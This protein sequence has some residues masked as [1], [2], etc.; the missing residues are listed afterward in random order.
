[1]RSFFY[2]FIGL[3]WANCLIAGQKLEVFELQNRDAESLVPVIA[4]TLGPEARVTADPRTNSLLVSYPEEMQENLRAIIAQLDQIE[5]NIEVETVTFDVEIAYLEKLGLTAR[6][7]L[8]PEDYATVLPLLI[9]DRRA[10][11]VGRQSVTTRGNQPARLSLYSAPA[12]HSE[13]GANELR[14]RATTL[15]VIP[16]EMADN[17]IELKF[18]HL[19]PALGEGGDP[20]IGHVFSAVMIENGGA[21]LFRTNQDFSLGRQAAIPI[22]PLGVEQHYQNKQQRVLVISA[23]VVDDESLPD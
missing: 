18:A 15:A 16:R 8:R 10:T 23:K 1:M 11:L 6:S 13:K 5:P 14:R 19:S 21:Q 17:I 9:E 7:G 12:I 4:S 22:F 3:L 2:I 20:G